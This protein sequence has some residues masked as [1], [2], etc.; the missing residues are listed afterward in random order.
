[1]IPVVVLAY[2]LHGAFLLVS[3]GIGIEKRA[4][5]YPMITAVAAGT[6]IVLDLALIPRFGM[7][8]AAWATVAGYLVMAALGGIVSHR[9]YP[10]PLEAGRLGLIML[11]AGVSYVLSWLAPA[12]IGPAIA[13]KLALFG[14]FTLA[15]V[16][17][18][19]LRWP[20]GGTAGR[21]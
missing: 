16:A 17:G 21:H 7:M 14:G 9:L 20:R 2:L 5:Y 4:R 13:V 19:V 11:A 10:I 1:V 15:L 3:I 18:G 6:N 12:G 8:G